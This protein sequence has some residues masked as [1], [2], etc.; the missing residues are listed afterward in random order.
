MKNAL[1]CK[2]YKCEK[3]VYWGGLC[4]KHYSS[5]FQ[6]NKPKF[7]KYMIRSKEERKCQDA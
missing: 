3:Q 6:R 1:K 4:Y 7:D 2:G 5:E